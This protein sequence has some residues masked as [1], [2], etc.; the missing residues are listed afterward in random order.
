MWRTQRS[1]ALPTLHV[2]LKLQYNSDEQEYRVAVFIKNILNEDQTYYTLD[3]DDA[4]TTMTMM[5]KE[6]IKEVI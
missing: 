6:Y 1:K 5:I 4:E 3:V 2:T